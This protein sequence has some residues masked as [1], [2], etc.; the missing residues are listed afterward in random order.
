MSV[1]VAHPGWSSCVH[2]RVYKICARWPEK[3]PGKDTTEAAEW[4][5]SPGIASPGFESPGLL[6]ATTCE[7]PQDSPLNAR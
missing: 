4:G 7:Q 1:L 2:E 6:P 5:E 3:S